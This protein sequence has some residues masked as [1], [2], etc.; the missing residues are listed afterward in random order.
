MNNASRLDELEKTVA[1]PTVG[2][3]EKEVA[4]QEIAKIDRADAD[5]KV[6]PKQV[7]GRAQEKRFVAGVGNH[8]GDVFGEHGVSAQRAAVD[9]GGGLPDCGLQPALGS[10]KDG[11][12]KVGQDRL[13]GHTS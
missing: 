13:F 8:G 9:D 3:P 10:G 7:A 1:A 2:E 5:Q 12:R 11:E 4:R 6:L